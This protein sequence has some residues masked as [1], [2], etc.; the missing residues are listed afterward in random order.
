MAGHVV[1][2]TGP[3]LRASVG[4]ALP[5]N[6]LEGPQHTFAVRVGGPSYVVPDEVR[7]IRNGEV[8]DVRPAEASAPV[9]GLWL[10]TTFEIDETEDAWYVVE[11]EGS[12]AMGHIWRGG[13]P[14]A[15]TGAFLV[16]VDGNGWQAPGL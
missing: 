8:V 4:A 5:G 14:Y 11:T 3:Q 7:L 2:S 16:D 6:T 13:T 9:N 1:V 12:S 10:E 15:M